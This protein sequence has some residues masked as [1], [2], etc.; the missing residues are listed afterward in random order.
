MCSATRGCQRL[1]RK[2]GLAAGCA[3]RS[4]VHKNFHRADVR[5]SYRPP[6]LRARPR[7]CRYGACRGVVTASIGSVALAMKGALLSGFVRSDRNDGVGHRRCSRKGSGESTA[8][9]RLGPPLNAT[10]PKSTAAAICGLTTGGSRRRPDR[11]KRDREEPDENPTDNPSDHGSPPYQGRTISASRNH[12]GP[13]LFTLQL[14]PTDHR[15]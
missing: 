9:T 13:P 10:D 7:R 11:R 15:F 1:I 14:L 3:C 6:G 8:L 5:C 12:R 2:S 4:R